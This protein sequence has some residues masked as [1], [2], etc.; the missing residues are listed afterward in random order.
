M[1]V[2]GDAPDTSAVDGRTARRDRNRTAVLDAVLE[3][4]TEGMLDPNPEEVARRSG[5]SLRSVYRYVADRDDLVRAA[6]ARHVEKNAPLF[7]LPGLGE[8]PLGDRIE[9]FVAA[10]VRLYDAIGAT[11]RASRRRAAVN[12]AIRTQV[13]SGY[14]RMR[15]QM[16]EH[17]ARELDALAP[18]ERR[19]VAAAVDT[20]TQIEAIEHLREHSGYSSRVTREILV[21]ILGRLL[22]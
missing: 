13:E 2:T 15:Q 22:R 12:D 4:F 21:D 11:H 17:F 6:I 10:R 16:A 7:V 14:R 20:L 9:R 18:R 8:G 5:V 19:S 3:L 1:T